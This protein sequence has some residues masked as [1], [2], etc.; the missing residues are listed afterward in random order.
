MKNK[1]TRN[2]EIR[3][4]AEKVVKESKANDIRVNVYAA[5]A[6]LN[7]EVEMSYDDVKPITGEIGRLLYK[8]IDAADQE[9]VKD[10]KLAEKDVKRVM[11]EANKELQDECKGFMVTIKEFH[12]NLLDKI[13]NLP[14]EEK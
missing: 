7:I 10:A 8:D 9:D 11:F 5:D 4:I 1:L 6:K 14:Y 2:M 13:K 3:K 12:K